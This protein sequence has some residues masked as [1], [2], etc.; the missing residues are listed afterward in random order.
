MRKM[1]HITCM[2]KGVSRTLQHRP[3]KSV[4]LTDSV[5]KENNLMLDDVVKDV[6]LVKTSYSQL[7]STQYL[8]HI[9]NLED[10][11]RSLLLTGT[12]RT[13]ST[14]LSFFFFTSGFL[15]AR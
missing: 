13:L 5:Q 4:S 1:S 3:I 8:F 2:R 11:Y 7:I 15:Q 14:D 9:Y 12:S 10:R 6:P